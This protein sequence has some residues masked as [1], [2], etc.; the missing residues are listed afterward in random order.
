MRAGWIHGTNDGFEYYLTY[1]APPKHVSL[2]D[3]QNIYSA[4]TKV[5]S[6]KEGTIP[7]EIRRGIHQIRV[8]FDFVP[9]NEQVELAS[10]TAPL[11]SS[12]REAMHRLLKGLFVS[13]LQ[14]APC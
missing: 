13:K 11:R 9:A 1:P 8:A 5:G 6:F 3:L 4:E 10:L 7:F 14:F 12:D 2:G